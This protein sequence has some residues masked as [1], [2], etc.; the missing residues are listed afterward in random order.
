MIRL[1]IA[2]L[3]TAAAASPAETLAEAVASRRPR[4]QDPAEILAE[5]TAPALVTTTNLVVTTKTAADIAWER[6][7]AVSITNLATTLTGNPTNAIARV[8]A[9]RPDQMAG[10]VKAR[11]AADPG[12]ADAMVQA[13]LELLTYH[14]AALRRGY[15]WPLPEHFAR[16]SI[17][18]T[19]VTIEAS[20]PAW[21]QRA[22]LEQAPSVEQIRTL[23]EP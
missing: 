15:T 9:L 19:T 18:T 13:S 10:L 17:T 3:L 2:I 20:G 5:L 7:A 11:I 1:L 23:M 4:L 16:A 12:N 6:A 21:W 14:A 22:G 8:G